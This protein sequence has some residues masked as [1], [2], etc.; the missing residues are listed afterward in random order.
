MIWEDLP[1]TNTPITAENL[2]KIGKTIIVTETDTDLNDYVEEGI[3]FFETDYTPVNVPSNVGNGWLHVMSGTGQYGT[4]IKQIWYR[5]GT[6]NTNDFE[7]YVRTR[8]V[9]EEWSNWQQFQNYDSGWQNATLSSAFK[10]YNDDSSNTPQYRKI[11]KVVEI[12]GAVA[13]TSQIAANSITV[14]FN[15]PAGFRPSKE[16][17][18]IQQGSELNSWLLQVRPSGNVDI[19]RYGTTTNIAIP[20]TAWLP[21]NFTFTID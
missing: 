15:L 9:S 3:Y 11:G 21:F 20:T 7:T 5:A 19:A 2:N 17:K 13:P 18:S 14:M 8:N 10:N 4:R 6:V 12:R 16:T 1:S